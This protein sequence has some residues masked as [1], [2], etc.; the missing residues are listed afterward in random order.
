MSAK[1]A[2]AFEREQ[3]R[4]VEAYERKKDFARFCAGLFVVLAVFAIA[5]GYVITT[6]SKEPTRATGALMTLLGLAIPFVLPKK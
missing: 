4:G 2:A 6:P 5:A 3:K 1:A